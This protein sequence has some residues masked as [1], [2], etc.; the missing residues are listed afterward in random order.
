MHSLELLMH[1]LTCYE[2]AILTAQ[3][4][5]KV[6]AFQIQVFLLCCYATIA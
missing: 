5:Y 1:L 6:L 3:W 4:N 2:N